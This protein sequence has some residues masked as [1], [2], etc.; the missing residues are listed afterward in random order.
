MTKNSTNFVN[1]YDE[2]EMK[3]ANWTEKNGF[4]LVDTLIFFRLVCWS[5]TKRWKVILVKMYSNFGCFCSSNCMYTTTMHM[6]GWMDRWTNERVKCIQSTKYILFWVWVLALSSF[7]VAVAAVQK[8]QF[9][10][11]TFHLNT[12][13]LFHFVRGA[14]FHSCENHH[15]WND[16][17]VNVIL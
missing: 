15:S 6:N 12:S 9:P 2:A 17:M 8:K 14:A 1:E 3:S 13:H 4:L 10:L 16:V 11:F 5:N 7:N